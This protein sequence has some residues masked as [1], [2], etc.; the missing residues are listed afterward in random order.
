MR[1]AFVAPFGMG[2]KTTVWAR[3]LPLAAGLAL[4][5]HDVRVVV[6]P[7]DSPRESGT[8]LLH[9]QVEV[10][11]VSIQ[12]GLLPTLGRMQW[13]VR[14]FRPE[15]VHIVKP[16]AF[17]GLTQVLELLQREA[18]GAGPVVLLDADDWEQAWTP[19]LKAPAWL[20]RFLAWQEE[21]GFRRCDGITAA[22]QWL[23]RRAQICA[24]RVPRLY[25]PNGAD[26]A[27]APVASRRRD[28][29]PTVLW[30]TRFAETSPA[31][32]AACWTAL[33]AS[34]PACRLWIVGSSIEPHW[35]R[36]FRQALADAGADPAAVQWLGFVPR[37]ELKALYA[38]AHCVIAPARASAENLAKCSVKLLDS[39]RFGTRCVASDV[40]EQARFRAWPNVTLVEPTADAAA[41]AAAVAAALRPPAASAAARGAR[42]ALPTWPELA[43][44]LERFYRQRLAR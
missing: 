42:N 34:V 41:F 25:L 29:A 8:V 6:P 14:E 2:Q 23:W 33:K 7:W 31:W 19:A 13:R 15:I 24:P 37:A 39:V 21:W 27:D 44:H 43:A 30:A 20:A 22:S 1:I 12:G 26:P 17:A 4:R 10:T 11:R 38:R 36:P 3:T 9:K 32:M 40:G 35:D 16:R 18:L 5:A 28:A